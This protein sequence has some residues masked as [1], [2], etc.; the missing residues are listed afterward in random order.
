MPLILQRNHEQLPG[1][2]EGSNDLLPAI[3]SP[4]SY[5]SIKANNLDSFVR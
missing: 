3:G 5:Y 4:R 2:D 1:T